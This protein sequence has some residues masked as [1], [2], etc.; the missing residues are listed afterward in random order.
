MP[1]VRGGVETEQ[2]SGPPRRV[3][4]TDGYW[5]SLTEPHP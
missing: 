3:N 4:A 1:G 5:Y 2:Q